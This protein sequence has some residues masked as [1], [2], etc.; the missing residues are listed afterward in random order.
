MLAFCVMPD[1]V[2]TVVLNRRYPLQSVVRL[3]KR[4]TT[5]RL[6][7]LG[8]SPT[9]WQRG[10]HDHV[11]RRKEGLFEAI[12]YV[13]LNPVRAGIAEHWRD[14]PWSGSIEWPDLDDSFM[15]DA[16]AERVVISQL[17]GTD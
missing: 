3:L 7:C 9:I 16:V 11:I 5:Q 10:Y 2:H 17:L 13:L 4:E 14:Y 1:H 8:V 15:D 12:R 6:K